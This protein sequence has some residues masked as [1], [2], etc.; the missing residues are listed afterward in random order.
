VFTFHVII[1]VSVSLEVSGGLFVLLFC[2]TQLCFY[3][4]CRYML[5]ML[6][7]CK[8]LVALRWP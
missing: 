6:A 4:V 1:V 8:W 3:M 2:T 7:S 5:P